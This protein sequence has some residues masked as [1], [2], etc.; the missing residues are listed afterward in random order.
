MGFKGGLIIGAGI[1]YVLGAKA[2][3]GRYDEIMES[4][5]EL[6]ARPEVQDIIAKGKGLMDSAA[7]AARERT[8]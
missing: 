5:S 2:G 1:G 3:R 7:E 8:T 4:V 6:T